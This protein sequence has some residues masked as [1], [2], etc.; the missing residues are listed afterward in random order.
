MVVFD[1][2]DCY[3]EETHANFFGR[4]MPILKLRGHLNLFDYVPIQVL[5]FLNLPPP[6]PVYEGPIGFWS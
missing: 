4:L 6:F 3:V 2:E 5:G 1:V